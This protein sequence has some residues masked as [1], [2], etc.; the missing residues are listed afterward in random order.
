MHQVYVCIEYKGIYDN[1][2]IMTIKLAVF[3]ST[4]GTSLQP[5]ID[6]INNNELYGV[7]ITFVFSNIKKAYILER[8]R[9]NGIKDIYL[10]SK[11]LSR[12]EYDNE[13]SDLLEKYDI[14]LVLLI[15]YM[16]LITKSFVNKWKN[17]IMNIHPSILPAFA[18]GMDL[19][20]H[21]AVIDR[22]CKITGASLIFI[23]ENADTGPIISQSVVTVDNNETPDTLKHKVQLVE[24][25][26]LIEGIRMWRDGK[27]NIMDNKVYILE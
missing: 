9:T 18:G 1:Y 12:E 23:D 2:I 17:K 16:K 4:K 22:G 21:Q 6:S 20:V 26:L 8:A 3:G 27:I 13:V 7:E 19:N 14:D 25:Q 11:G 24:Q 10:P 15:G 5:I